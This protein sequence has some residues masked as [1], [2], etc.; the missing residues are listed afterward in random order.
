MRANKQRCPQCGA[1]NKERSACRICGRVLPSIDV[2]DNHVDLVEIELR[3]WNALS[4]D[5]VYVISE[6]SPPARAAVRKHLV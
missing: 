6:P 1:R 4:A 5:P 2:T 3:N